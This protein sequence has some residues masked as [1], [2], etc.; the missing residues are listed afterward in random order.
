MSVITISTIIMTNTT[1]PSSPHHNYYYHHYHHM[2]PIKALATRK[3]L[4]KGEPVKQDAL[5]VVLFR[6]T[7]NHL[8]KLCYIQL[9]A[10]TQTAPPKVTCYNK[11]HWI[12]ETPAEA[13]SFLPFPTLVWHRARTGGRLPRPPRGSLTWLCAWATHCVPTHRAQKVRGEW[14][15]WVAMAF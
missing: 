15:K 1:F 2:P 3:R 11:C 5:K 7:S 4:G 14:S 9:S 12:G 8:D 10:C 13:H 6:E